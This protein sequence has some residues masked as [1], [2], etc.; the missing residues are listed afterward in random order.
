[1]TVRMPRASSPRRSRASP[2]RRAPPSA[3]PLP[4]QKIEA[5]LFTHQHC[6]YVLGIETLWLLV[7]LALAVAFLF[8]SS[9]SAFIFQVRACKGYGFDDR[10]WPKPSSRY[11]LR[12]DLSIECFTTPAHDELVRLM[13]VFVAV[14]PIGVVVCYVLVL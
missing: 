5:A 14:W 12:A 9:V 13:W 7:P 6:R 2:P 11:F 4:K 10:A 8:V 1:M 3:R